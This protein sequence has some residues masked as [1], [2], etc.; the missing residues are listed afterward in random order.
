MQGQA[1]LLADSRCW[2]SH[3]HLDRDIRDRSCGRLSTTKDALATFRLGTN[4][5]ETYLV[6]AISVEDMLAFSQLADLLGNVVVAQANQTALP[7][8]D[9]NGVSTIESFCDQRS[10]IFDKPE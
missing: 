9:L 7:V 2:K 3:A 4:W 10:R 8:L 5:N 1:R 6:N